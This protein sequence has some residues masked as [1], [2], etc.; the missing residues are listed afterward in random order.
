MSAKSKLLQTLSWALYAVALFLIYH[1]VIK[2]AFLDFS[3]IALVLFLPL[4]AVVYLIIRP[5]ERRH[6]IVFTLGFLMLDRALTRLDTDSL[7]A[8]LFGGAVAAIVIALLVKWYGRLPWRAVGALV[9]IA[10]L[11]NTGFNRDN[12]AVLNHFIIQ[13]ES[14]KLYHGS[15][16]DYFPVTLYDVDQDGKQEI[17]TYGNADQLPLEPKAERPETEAERKALAEKLLPLKAE[18]VSFYVM[19]WKD[20]KL[21]RMPNENIPADTWERITEKMPSDF[22]GFPYYTAKDGQLVPNVQRQSYA[23]GMLQAGTAPYRAFL[24]DMLNVEEMLKQ[25]G[26][27]MDAR[28]SFRDDSRF[29]DLVLEAG[30]LTGT[31]DGKPF[32]IGIEATKLINTMKL[33]DGREGLLVLGEHLSVLVVN[34]DGSVREAYTLTRKQAELATTEFILADIDRDNVD[35]MLLAGTPSYILKPKPDGAWEILWS[36]QEG[37]DAFRF[38][39]YAAVGDNKEPE[40]IAKAKSWVSTTF[41]QRYLSGFRYTAEGL[42]QQWKI[43]LPLIN[44]QVGDIDGDKQNEIVAVNYNKKHQLLILKKHHVPVLPLVIALFVGLLGYGLVRRFRHV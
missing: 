41:Q 8:V 21:V 24:L 16:V 5:Q 26:G 27:K 3:W 20:G 22:P 18:P 19:T 25:N 7:V 15:W 43:Y 30:R 33:P 38:T 10:V 11:A 14:E 23:E 37:D 13:W 35:E 40:I 36:S 39:H 29:R 34:P 2:V 4:L 28:R 44:V 12:L 32:A 17:I 9:L 6:V 42:E 1:L 31:Y